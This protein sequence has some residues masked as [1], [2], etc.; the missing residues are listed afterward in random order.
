MTPPSP[1]VVA[2][3]GESNRKT[4]VCSRVHTLATPLSRQMQVTPGSRATYASAKRTTLP[5][6][7]IAQALCK[8]GERT[9]HNKPGMNRCEHKDEYDSILQVQCG[10]VTRSFPATSLGS[11]D[12]CGG[13]LHANLGRARFLLEEPGPFPNFAQVDGSCLRRGSS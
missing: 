3:I 7:R 13:L 2:T 4:N 1:A 10:S 11:R 12:S 5:R 6:G 9:D 8:K